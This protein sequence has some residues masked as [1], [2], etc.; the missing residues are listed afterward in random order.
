MLRGRPGDEEWRGGTVQE[1]C[2]EQAHR[3]RVGINVRSVASAE[4]AIKASAPRQHGVHVTHDEHVLVC[5]SRRVLDASDDAIAHGP[6]DGVG[7]R[8]EVCEMESKVV[9]VE[10]EVAT[11]DMLVHVG[12]E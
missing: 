8:G 2:S 3:G 5:S 6:R 9:R 1:A 7:A 12:E 10:H 4:A 11:C